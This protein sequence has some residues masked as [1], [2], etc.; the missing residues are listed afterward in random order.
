MLARVVLPDGPTAPLMTLKARSGPGQIRRHDQVHDQEP[1]CILAVNSQ[2]CV[3]TPLCEG[4]ARK[5]PRSKETTD[6]RFR[7]STS[8]SWAWLD[9]NQR[10]HPY[11]MDG[12]PLC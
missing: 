2:G 12:R 1:F 7:R 11:Q 3:L 5:Q 9:L 10:P 6:E 8:V 4:D